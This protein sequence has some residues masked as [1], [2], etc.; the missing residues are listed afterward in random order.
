MKKTAI[1]LILAF[2][3]ALAAVFIC[4][5]VSAGSLTVETELPPGASKAEITVAPSGVIEI[6]SCEADPDNGTYRFQVRSVSDGEASVLLRW[7]K[8]DDPVFYTEEM[9]MSFRSVLGG[10][11]YDEIT[12]NFS[13]WESIFTVSTVLL[14][15]FCVIL[16]VSF[17][18]EQ[19]SQGI[20]TYRAVRLMG[21]TIF[22]FVMAVIRL[23]SLFRISRSGFGTAYTALVGIYFMTQQFI[24]WTAPVVLVL[25]SALIISNIA[26][27]K[28]EGFSTRNMFGIVIGV[29][30]SLAVLIGAELYYHRAEYQFSNGLISVF[31][32]LATYFECLMAATVISA[33]RAALYT[34]DHD[35]DYVMVLGCKIRPDGTLY[36]LIRGRVDRAV[37]FVREQERLTGK[38]AFLVPSGG[39]G[40]DERLSEAEAMANYMISCG[41]SPERIL[42]E[43]RSTTTRE[44]LLFSRNLISERGGGTRVAF[45]TSNYHVFRGGI[46]AGQLGWRIDGMGSE[47]KWY[48]W[49][50][51]FMREFIGLLA[52]SW[53]AQ[54]AAIILVTAISWLTAAII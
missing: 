11:V 7:D 51:A 40:S 35:K 47:T 9:S 21:F 54:T 41:I 4:T 39:K 28:K 42:V 25:S 15:V 22:L 43:N 2:L 36:P 32:G 27:I 19:K 48:Y 23:F 16:F 6:V 29:T 3:L 33:L 53:K 1:N 31:A 24:V 50:N 44:N 52:D 26:L 14:F 10:I 38:K 5:K 20:Y 30:I 12:S 34:P 49:P 45:S 17:L 46:L 37:T 18:K 13:G 8:V